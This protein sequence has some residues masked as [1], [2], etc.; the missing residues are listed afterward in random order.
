MLLQNCPSRESI[1]N[2]LF[3]HFI[4]NFAQP[5]LAAKR[6]VRYWSDRY[7]LF[8]PNKFV[9]PMTL[10]G[11]MRDDSLALSRGYV[12]LLPETDT[13]GR[14]VIYIDWSSHEPSVGYSEE[15]LVS[16]HTYAPSLCLRD[17]QS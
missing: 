13:A 6:L 8:G 17:S 1:S 12:Q 4:S 2:T 11:A 7:R 3:I 9:S 15:S 5:Q 14:A 16:V 10:K